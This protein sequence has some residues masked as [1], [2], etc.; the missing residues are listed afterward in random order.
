MQFRLLVDCYSMML[1]QTAATHQLGGTLDAVITREDV[2][3]P[4]L[5]KVVDVGLSD[6]HLLQWSVDTTRPEVPVVVIE[7]RRS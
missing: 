3:C 4:D 1:H 6:H 7:L 2:G 5:V